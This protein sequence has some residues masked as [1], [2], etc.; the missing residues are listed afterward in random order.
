MD[1]IHQ[2]EDWLNALLEKLNPAERRKLMRDVATKLRQQQQQNIRMQ[3]NP[4]GSGFEPRKVSGRAKQGRIKSQMFS[5]LRTTRYMKTRATADTAEV[6]F[7][8]KAQRIA[9]VHHYGLR[10]RVRKGG[11]VVAYPRR[12]LLGI[13]KMD[14]NTVKDLIINLLS[15]IP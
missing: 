4:D 9:R 8:A 5:K 15:T 14:E 13:T 6:G 10:D 2:V 12:E 7:D 3:K 1:N 11:P